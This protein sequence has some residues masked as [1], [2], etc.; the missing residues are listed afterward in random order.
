MENENR[1]M[2][3]STALEHALKKREENEEKDKT[4]KALSFLYGSYEPKF[5]W[6]EIFETLRK[7]ALTGFLVFI[8]PGTT[9]QVVVSLVMSMVALGVYLKTEPFIDSFNNTS[10]ACSS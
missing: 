6:F 7:L 1:E 2:K 5:W 4:V 10:H 3:R 8:A 9:A